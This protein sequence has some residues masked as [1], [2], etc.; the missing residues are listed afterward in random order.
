M[1]YEW[2]S[3]TVFARNLCWGRALLFLASWVGNSWTL[4]A[5]K[6]LCIYVAMIVNDHEQLNIIAIAYIFNHPG[7][8]TSGQ[9]CSTED[10]L[11][12]ADLI[13][14]AQPLKVGVPGGTDDDCGLIRL[15][16]PYFGFATLKLWDPPNLILQSTHATD[17]WQV[18]SIRI[19]RKATM[20]TKKAVLHALQA[21]RMGLQSMTMVSF[22][23]CMPVMTGTLTIINDGDHRLRCLGWCR[24]QTHW[25][26]EFDMLCFCTVPILVD[27]S[28]LKEMLNIALVYIIFS[29]FNLKS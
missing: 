23:S 8:H 27:M 17:T 26:V 14:K 15:I 25:V 16:S 24:D 2:N 7:I 29:H 4:T 6:R 22:W 21:R 3:C 20:G 12:S 9:P 10:M 13:G 5:K 19:F 1:N 28:G 11:S 18:V